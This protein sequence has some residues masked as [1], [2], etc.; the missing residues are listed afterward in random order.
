M[1]G[2]TKS[3]GEVRALRGVD[4]EVR[5][6]EIFGFL[7]PNGAGKTTTIRCLLDLIR[8]NGG[9]ARVMGIDPQADP[10]AVRAQVGYLPGELSLE[11]NLRVEGQLRYFKDLRGNK[12]D[13]AFVQ[14]V[15]QR[16]KP[17]RP[18]IPLFA[19]L[20]LVGGLALL[21]SFLLPS[22]RMAAML[23][24]GLLVG[25]FLLDGLA[26]A[27]AG[28]K[29]ITDILP[30]HFHQGGDAM[31]GL[32]WAWLLGLLAVSLLFAVLAWLRFQRRDIRVGGEGGWQLAL[33]WKK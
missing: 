16:L 20:L 9:I 4:L 26:N 15:A 19:I 7:G 1:Q 14:E 22:A 8:P 30:L 10:V 2:L 17:L 33:P 28:L 13:W 24:S 27:N 32:N 18:F 25:N 23:A 3:Y 6:G 12:I 29:K 5:Q 11:D 31:T 21:L